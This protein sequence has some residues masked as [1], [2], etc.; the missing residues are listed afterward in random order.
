MLH[1][2]LPAVVLGVAE[3]PDT[4]AY[5]P[6][7]P[8]RVCSGAPTWSVRWGGRPQ[9]LHGGSTAILA[10]AAERSHGPTR[11]TDMVC[12]VKALEGG[13]PGEAAESK[14]EATPGPPHIGGKL[15]AVHTGLVHLELLDF[16]HILAKE[17]LHQLRDSASRA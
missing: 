12:D 4:E 15:H 17:F 10:L 8:L 14:P 1:E 5:R 11:A 16:N 13:V 3:L 2:L 9:R 7:G 6:G